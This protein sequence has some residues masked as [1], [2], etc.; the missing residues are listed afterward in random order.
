M[1]YL[2]SQMVLYLVIA[3]GI[4]LVM[5][6][7]LRGALQRPTPPE[8]SRAQTA[9]PRSRDTSGVGRGDNPPR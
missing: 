7:S 4:G 1:S 8:G 3:A 5:G 2:I 9:P 6:W